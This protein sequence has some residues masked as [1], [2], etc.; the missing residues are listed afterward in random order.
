MALKYE[1]KDYAAKDEL[2]LKDIEGNVH[3]IPILVTHEDSEK[4][5]AFNE[6]Q[7]NEEIRVEDKPSLT[8]DEFSTILFKDNA[9]KVKEITGKDYENCVVMVGFQLMSKLFKNKMEYIK[10]MNSMRHTLKKN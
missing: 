3:K 7:N 1:V 8:I 4:L 2:E 10:S 5:L 9:D 6:A